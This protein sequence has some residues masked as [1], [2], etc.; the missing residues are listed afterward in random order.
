[1][2]KK[3]EKTFLFF[4][5][6]G[7][8][9]LWLLPDFCR[10]IPAAPAL[11]PPL[12]TAVGLLL[13]CLLSDFCRDR[14]ATQ[15]PA[16]PPLPP[17]LSNSSSFTVAMVTV[18]LLQRKTSSTSPCTPPPTHPQTAVG[19]LLLCLLSNFCRDRPATSALA[20]PPPTPP[21]TPLKQQLFYCCYGYCLT[22]AETD[23]QHQPLPPPKAAAQ[24]LKSDTLK[25]VQQWQEKYGDAYKKLALG[26][27]FL[28]TCKHVSDLFEPFHSQLH[29]LAWMHDN[30][31]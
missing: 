23:Q 6:I 31:V 29:I 16:P 14:P 22:F 5:E 30:P 10:E 4:C 19:L 26:Y 21:S 3:K 28:Q 2:K 18:W 12:Q 9:L 11:A 24:K 13:L 27:H 7:L 15:A 8:L 1:M 25:A 17:L 20:P